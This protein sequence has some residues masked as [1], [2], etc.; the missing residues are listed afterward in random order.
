MLVPGQKGIEF[1]GLIGKRSSIS[2][3]CDASCKVADCADRLSYVLQKLRPT[4][5]VVSLFGYLVERM[6]ELDLGP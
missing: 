3:I 1:V 6:R 4:T 2:E 5:W